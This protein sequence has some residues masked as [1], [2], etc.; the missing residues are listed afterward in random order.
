MRRLAPEEWSGLVMLVVCA[1]VSLPVILGW[2][3]TT[4][5]YPLWLALFA[6]A[7]LAFVVAALASS[8][9]GRWA[10]GLAIFAGWVLLLTVDFPGLLPILLVMLAAF[11]PDLVTGRTTAV[12]IAANTV[13]IGAATWRTDQGWQNTAITTGFYLLIQIATYFSVAAISREQRLRGELSEAHVELQAQSVLLEETS[14]SAE[15]LRISRD[16]HDLIGHQLTVLTLELEAARHREG[17]ESR[18]HVERADRVAR[19]LLADVRSTVGEL[20]DRPTDLARALKQVGKDAPGLDVDVEVEGDIV[21]DEQQT[22]AIVRAMQEIVTNTL[23]HARAENLMVDVRRDGL[24]VML[25]AADDGVGASGVRLG[26]G[27]NGLTERFAALGGAVEF[28][29]EQGFRVEARVPVR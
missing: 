14:R 5:P 13:V 1:G 6:I 7:F 18:E 26:N 22:E 23:R 25:R 4:I 16:L 8:G 2:S 20:R 24:M 15:R 9:L 3:V 28:D 12:I 27:L 17:T 11:G 10:Y 21:L 19:D 29:G